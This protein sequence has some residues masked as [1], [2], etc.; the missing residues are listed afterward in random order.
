[1]GVD[2]REP[3]AL[4]TDSYREEGIA[5][6]SGLGMKITDTLPLKDFTSY[7]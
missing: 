3:A 4:E 2:A 7:E 6:L 5:L 1:M